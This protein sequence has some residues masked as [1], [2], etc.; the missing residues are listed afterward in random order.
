MVYNNGVTVKSP[1]YW[2]RRSEWIEKQVR[3]EVDQVNKQLIEGYNLILKDIQNDIS[4]F[5]AI[6]DLASMSK[7][8]TIKDYL[9]QMDWLFN[10]LDEAKKSGI[11]NPLI[12]QRINELNATFRMTR[13]QVLER[14]IQGRLT[15]YGIETEQKMTEALKDVYLS[16]YDK[17][18][19]VLQRGIGY[20]YQY[21]EPNW[22][23]I[24]KT[25]LYPWA[26]DGL[27]FSDRIWDYVDQESKNFIKAVRRVIASDIIAQGKNPK[28]VARDIV[29]FGKPS[30]SASRL[31]FNATRLLYTE[32]SHIL[33]EAEADVAKEWGIK[34]YVYLATLDE[35][36]SAICQSLD[37]KK[38]EY[39]NRQPGINYPPMHP[40]CRSTVYDVVPNALYTKRASRGADGKTIHEIPAHV[41][42]KQ[43]QE[44]QRTGKKTWEEGGY[45]VDS[46]MKKHDFLKADS[47]KRE[48]KSIVESW[49]YKVKTFYDKLASNFANN[50]YYKKGTGAYYPSEKVIRMD[51]DDLSWEYYAK[52]R[53][54]GNWH[55][56]FHE[57]F[58]QLDHILAKTDFS[59]DGSGIRQRRLTDPS[60]LVGKKISEAI[61]K[62]I[63]NA[64]NN[65][66]DK[67][68]KFRPWNFKQ[69]HIES[70]EKVSFDVFDDFVDW[71]ETEFD[72]DEKRAF[73]DIFTD[74][75]SLHTEG[76]LTLREKGFWGHRKKYN[77]EKGKAGATSEAWATFGA[78]KLQNLPDI[79]ELNKKLMPNT[80]KVFE[81]I[82]EQ[83]VDYAQDNDLKY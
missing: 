33:A 15:L 57:E 73:I 47:Q 26:E 35:R 46:I 51:M 45:L 4:E 63:V 25:I 9:I 1:S 70:I 53:R 20:G 18:Q 71:L 5:I 28:T 11:N 22:K 72:T 3:K 61:E 78:L 56:K 77:M 49:D 14:Q 74:A 44:F 19:F 41:T 2:V 12:I 52:T 76:R 66:I 37:G 27:M 17:K 21:N 80:F 40:M 68:N 60:S 8:V 54:I 65:A 48:F 36:T 24:E 6:N 29:G 81:E 75:I 7:M 43:W 55:V 10:K 42:Y 30:L 83:V 67:A 64:I 16:A 13:L 32:A 82:F 69:K 39:K 79:Y 50:D 62:D 59:L 23:A 34:E 31:K 38:F 58:H